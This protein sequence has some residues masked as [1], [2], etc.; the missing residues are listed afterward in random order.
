MKRL[1]LALLTASLALFSMSACAGHRNHG[2]HKAKVVRAT[3]I[4]ETARYA[5][6]EQVCWDEQVWQ[7]HPPT[8]V[9]T[10]VSYTHLRAHETS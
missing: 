5:V 6:D 3:P 1:N 7:R 2:H 4:Y 10:A 8:A 9:P